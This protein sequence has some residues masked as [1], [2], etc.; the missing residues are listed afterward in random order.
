MF[1]VKSVFVCVSILNMYFVSVCVQWKANNSTI[2]LPREELL[3]VWS[4]ENVIDPADDWIYY[5]ISHLVCV[6]V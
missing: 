5:Y 6:I 3:I 2:V 4:L 1:E